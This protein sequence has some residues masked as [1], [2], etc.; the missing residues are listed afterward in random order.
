[1]AIKSNPFVYPYTPFHSLSDKRF[2]AKFHDLKSLST[3]EIE[4]IIPHLSLDSLSQKDD[5]AKHIL[6]FL[7]SNSIRFGPLELTED[8]HCYWIEK[9]NYFISQSL[10]IQFTILGFPFKIPVPLKTNR[11]HPDMGELL[12]L[13]HLE[14]IC[15]TITKIYNPG[16]HIS[17]FAEG[18]FGKFNGTAV[19]EYRNYKSTLDLF[20]KKFHLNHLSIHHLDEMEKLEPNFNNLFAAKVKEFTEGFSDGDKGISEKVQ[21]TMESILRIVNTKT[22]HLSEETLMDVYNYS[23]PPEKVTPEISTT[24]EY[25]NRSAQNVIFNYLSYLSVRDDIQ[26]LERTVPHGLSLTVS[27]KKFRLGIQPI[28]TD[29]TK[30]PYHGVP[31]FHKANHNFTI[32][33]LIDIK[34][35]KTEIT[36][37]M[38]N[39]DPEKK[40]FYYEI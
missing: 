3:A 33:Y 8:L 21:G 34:R 9:L 32:E 29:I 5:P 4:K 16:A 39:S 14:D 22:L 23:L 11:T 7:Q 15:K 20:T 38:W 36:P 25:I 27:P 30:L 24:R 10:P 6:K 40:P 17:V 12:S 26:F 2:Q 35:M 19:E 37:V 31:V 13:S 1:M 18:V 28:S